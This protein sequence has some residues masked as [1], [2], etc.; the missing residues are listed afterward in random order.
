[1]PVQPDGS[2]SKLCAQ[3]QCRSMA[4]YML[5]FVLQLAV[6]AQQRC[7]SRCTEPV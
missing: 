7:D 1:M 4:T 3:T 6:P 2:Y 5:L